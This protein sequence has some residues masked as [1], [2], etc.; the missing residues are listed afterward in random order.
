MK[1]EFTY[2]IKIKSEWFVNLL[3]LKYT[4]KD[5][6]DR[7]TTQ[8][9]FFPCLGPLV[10]VLIEDNSP[11]N[12]EINL[13]NQNFVVITNL[14]ATFN[15]LL[16]INYLNDVKTYCY[17][18]YEILF[19]MKNSWKHDRIFIDIFYAINVIATFLQEKSNELS[20]WNLSIKISKNVLKTMLQNLK[21]CI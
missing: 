15:K 21:N 2:F 6:M 9:R 3:I 18:T 14:N 7:T 13:I 1:I 5:L 20:Q 11:N 16:S 4:E 8:G 10:S 17:E 19:I 12:V